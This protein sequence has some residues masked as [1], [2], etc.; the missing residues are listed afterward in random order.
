MRKIKGFSYNIVDDADV[1]EHIEKQ[2]IQSKYIWGLVRKDMKGGDSDIEVLVK[3]YVSK[4]LKDK[5]LVSNNSQQ[6]VTNDAINNLLN[7]GK[8]N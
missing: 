8:T 2:P 7:I 1:I 6:K 4:L 5:E 3:K